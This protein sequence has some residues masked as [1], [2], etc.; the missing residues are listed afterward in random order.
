MNVTWSRRVKKLRNAPS[1]PRVVFALAPTERRGYAASAKLGLATDPPQQQHY[2]FVRR[3]IHIHHTK[4]CSHPPTLRR[5]QLAGRAVASR[6][7]ATNHKPDI[8]RSPLGT[9]GT[10]CSQVT[11]ACTCRGRT[12]GG[13]RR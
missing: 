12:A 5:G 4:F 13:R 2:P 10:I 11:A 9:V 7:G 8:P 1:I 6:P 3:L